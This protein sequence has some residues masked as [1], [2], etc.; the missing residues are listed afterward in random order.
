MVTENALSLIREREGLRLRLYNCPS[1]NCTVGFGHRVHGGPIDGRLSEAQ[2]ANGISKA[3]AENLLFADADIFADGV[4]KLAPQANQNQ[5]DALVSFAYNFGLRALA[6]STLLRKFNAGDAQRAA[7]EFTK[8]V[9][10]NGKPSEWLLGFRQREKAL[11][12][13]PL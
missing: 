12:L 1:Q 5:V 7:E 9:N 3:Q 6:Q 4:K 13:R 10:I 8:W 11:F 2:Y